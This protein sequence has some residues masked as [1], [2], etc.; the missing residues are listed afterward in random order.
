MPNSGPVV[1][2]AFEFESWLESTVIKK[3]TP[4]IVA[5]FEYLGNSPK[6]IKGLFINAINFRLINL[7]E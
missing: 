7:C 4:N 3:I 5:G 2:P 6:S 1:S